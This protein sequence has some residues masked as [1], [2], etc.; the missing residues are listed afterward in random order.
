MN[1]HTILCSLV[2]CLLIGAR[3]DAQERGSRTA[4][5]DDAR[6]L[7][8]HHSTG[9]CIWNGGVPQ[10]FEAYNAAHQTS[11]AIREQA[12]PK[13]SP[14]GWEN[15]PFDYWNIWVRHAGPRP[16]QEEPTLEMLTPRYDVIVFKHCFPA[17]NIEPDTG[18]GDVAS[19]D[20]RLENY[21]LQYAA[22][23]AK[24]HEFPETR[25]LVWTGAAQV[26]EEVDEASARRARTF[27]DWVREQ[28]DEPGDNIF[29][30]DFYD[31]ETGGSLYIRP[32]FA[33]GDAHPNE[34][35]SAR[36]APLFCQ[37]VVDIIRG[38]GDSGSITGGELPALVR[39]DVSGVPEPTPGSESPTPAAVAPPAASDED[40]VLDDAE[41]ASRLEA[42]WE[43]A[44]RYVEDGDRHAIRIDFSLGLQEDWGEYGLHRL[45]WTRPP[46]QNVDVSDYRYLAFRMKCNREVPLVLTL[47][48][49]PEPQG[50]RYQPHFGFS[51]YL[52]TQPDDWQQVVIDLTKLELA[53]EGEE[54]YAAA[55][56]PNRP[57]SLTALK[58]AV[59]DRFQESEFLL[60]DII[61]Y[62]QLPTG[63]RPPE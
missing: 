62:R 51:A 23:K 50:D 36:V 37:R 38:R 28:W 41:D 61:F 17:S 60:D 45:V 7:F 29:V 24:L 3:I 11:Y 19:R 4:L 47:V 30:W 15:F 26:A 57:Q 49:L 56:R 13:E 12:F 21:H 27:F 43:E 14:Y 9:E 44:A 8:L 55:G 34:S 22:L 35:F 63:V 39:S 6:I 2:A 5:S 10:W 46:E 1:G 59:N 42:R 18:R 48:T 31:L 20:K 33:S 53:A 25:F 52:D 40:W 54:A 32:E 16:Y 58:F